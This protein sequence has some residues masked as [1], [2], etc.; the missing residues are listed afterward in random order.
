MRVLE[1]HLIPIKKTSG[2]KVG[3]STDKS[4]LS[5]MYFSFTLGINPA[6][7][8]CK[9]ECFVNILSGTKQST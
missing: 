9:I 8:I 2:T 3:E 4:A 5:E 7:T 6:Y 1:N